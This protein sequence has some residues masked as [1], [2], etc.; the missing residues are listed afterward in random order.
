MIACFGARGLASGKRAWVGRIDQVRAGLIDSEY[1][2]D[3]STGRHGAA[4]EKQAVSFSPQTN[5]LRFFCDES[6][7]F[8]GLVIPDRL[9]LGWFI[10]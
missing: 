1:V 4:R 2:F 7:K 9:G 10:R 8:F 5:D 3:A 6:R